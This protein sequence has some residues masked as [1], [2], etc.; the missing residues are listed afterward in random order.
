MRAAKRPAAPATEAPSLTWS[1]AFPVAEPLAE[2]ED[3]VPVLEAVVDVPDTATVP[4]DESW[5]CEL[6]PYVEEEVVAAVE[7][8]VPLLAI[9][10]LRQSS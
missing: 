1:A 9:Q 4:D 10:L 8:V 6:E 7:V 2:L 3:D 5:V